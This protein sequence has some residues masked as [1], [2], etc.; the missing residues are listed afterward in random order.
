MNSKQKIKKKITL[1][2]FRKLISENRLS[3]LFFYAQKADENWLVWLWDNGFLDTIIEAAKYEE[4]K[5]SVRAEL[6]YLRRMVEVVPKEVAAILRNIIKK[7]PAKTHNTNIITCLLDITSVLPASSLEMV[8]DDIYAKKWI[9]YINKKRYTFMMPNYKRM[10]E[11][12]AKAKRYKCLLTLAANLMMV[13]DKKEVKQQTEIFT[14]NSSPF[15]YHLLSEDNIWQYLA[16]IKEDTAIV[17]ALDLATNTMAKI[18]TIRDKSS[19][20]G[21]FKGYHGYEFETFDFFTLSLDSAESQRSENE[22]IKLA[23]LIKS[24][25]ENLIKKHS[26]KA[27]FYYTEYIGDYNSKNPRIPDT[28]AMWR[29]RLCILSVFPDLFSDKL[30]KYFSRLFDVYHYFDIIGGAEYERA[31]KKCFP[32]LSKKYQRE[33]FN[34]VLEYFT[35][36]AKNKPDEEKIHLFS[37]S[38]LLSMINKE[39]KTNELKRAEEHG[40]G[41]KSHS[42]PAP[43]IQIGPFRQKEQRAPITE[44]EFAKLSIA[45]IVDKLCNDWKPDN[46]AKSYPFPFDDSPWIN[47]SGVSNLLTE[48]I[49]KRL[50]DY[51]N[52]SERFFDPQNMDSSYT[53]SY[54]G[55]ISKIIQ[56]KRQVNSSDLSDIDWSN[57]LRLCVTII[58]GTEKGIIKEESRKSRIDGIT[59]TAEWK[60]IYYEIA[61]LLEA[62]LYMKSGM[63]KSKCIDILKCRNEVLKILKFLIEYLN[64][65]LEFKQKEKLSAQQDNI[66]GSYLHTDNEDTSSISSYSI[67]ESS[68]VNERAY[69]TQDQFDD[70]INKAR[71]HAFT[72]FI[73]FIYLDARKDMNNEHLRIA[74]DAKKIYENI[75]THERSGAV[76][77]LFGYYFNYVYTWDKKWAMQLLP[78]VF[79]EEY[80]KNVLYMAAWEGFLSNGPK[81]YMFFM[82]EIQKLYQRGLKLSEIDHPQQEHYDGLQLKIAEHFALIFVHIPEKFN[83]ED[84]LFKELWAGDK[85]KGQSH[86]VNFIGRVFI[87]NSNNIFRFYQDTYNSIRKDH[88]ARQRLINLWEWVIENYNNPKVLAEFGYWI[89]LDDDL[90]DKKIIIKQIMRT[91]E[92][93]DGTLS[94]NIIDEVIVKL[95]KAAPQDTLKIIEF[96]LLG[97]GID[98]DP[99]GSRIIK[100]GNY[101][102]WKEA[103]RAIS[104]KAHTA[105]LIRELLEKDNEY[106]DLRDLL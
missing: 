25:I 93:T 84:K 91:I 7:I 99:I 63:D 40:L 102:P 82:P 83:T 32:H 87:N 14:S 45:E 3:L 47:E 34:Q 26:K 64:P 104:T 76:M 52:E 16:N 13:V 5:F 92:K 59:F 10:L 23:A 2:E 57:I 69:N 70:T 50:Q 12:L 44:E 54:F 88:R 81:E 75:L 11:T 98:N 74:D 61:I 38:R 71:K 22:Q 29:L 19:K 56:E 86:F 4:D 39:L 78:Q 95:A 24:L 53:H 37:G 18:I 103:I 21:T 28:R 66:S 94:G 31:L 90:F 1:E 27:D 30:Q 36:L 100:E 85:V 80:S 105:T 35:S 48:D 106:L 49:A 46:L 55:G 77:F 6:G 67:A 17:Q 58:V 33:Y 9:S 73:Y 65:A 8:L 20:K 42:E 62:I 96:A 51:I 89:P 43:V 72:A 97:K 68:S 79:S 15:Y 101:K 60:S 41:I